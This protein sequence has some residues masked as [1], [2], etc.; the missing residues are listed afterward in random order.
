MY[1]LKHKNIMSVLGVSIEDH[2]EP[3]VI[4]LREGFSNL[5]K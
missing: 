3:F 2:V 5:K 1:G 4:Y